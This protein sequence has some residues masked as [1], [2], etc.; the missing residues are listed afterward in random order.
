MATET[1][2]R[3]IADQ[4]E[5]SIGEPF[6]LSGSTPVSGGDINQALVLEDG[7]Q[8]YFVKLNRADRLSMFEAEAEG[9]AEL[10]ATGSVQAPAV[11]AT[12]SDDD[13]A[14]L[15]LEY[16]DLQPLHESAEARLGEALAQMHA[17]RQ[18][19]FGWYRDNTIGTTTQPNPHED[20]WPAFFRRYR[21]EH[22]LALAQR[23]SHDGRL[24]SLGRDLA[25]CI[26]EL[27]STYTPQPS[28]L[29]GDLW[30]GNAGMDARGQPWIYDP[31][32]YYG[33]R[34]S[35]L[36]MTELF[37]GFGPA[38]RAA[39]EAEWPLDPDYV[40]RRDLYQLYHVLNHLN[41]FGGGWAGSARRLM[42]RLLA[43]ARG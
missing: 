32:V 29:H 5:M 28:L 14:W 7:R 20:D 31:A 16:V 1:L 41:L 12:G 19:F 3:R 42:E 2:L 17:I 37:G 4:I 35:D 18:P 11:V 8:R 10:A 25:E 21:L 30:G 36:A 13:S 6:R 27:F 15:V 34:E 9:L 40:V 38:F 33:D 24:Q 26:P 39:Y 23:N 43:E 22:Q